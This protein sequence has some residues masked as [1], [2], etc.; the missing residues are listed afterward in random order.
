[1]TNKAQQVLVA[2]DNCIFTVAE[3]RLDVLLIQMKQEPFDGVWALPG[4]L[5]DDGE[6]LDGAAA[7]ILEEQTGLRHVYLEQLYSFDDESRDP[8]GRVVSIAYFSLVQ[9]HGLELRTTDKYRQV[10]FW[11]VEG[12]PG[13]L[14][15]DHETILGYARARLTAKVQYTNVMWSLLPEKFTL[16]QL[17]AAYETVLSRRLDKRNFRKKVSSLGIVEAS[18]EKSTGGRHRPAML[19]RFTS[20]EPEIAEVFR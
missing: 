4:G 19:Y 1:M 16:G 14:A 20:H 2:V 8:S 13:K 11:S 3:G 10:R 17:Q 18:G 9:R 5:I 6:R 15:Y 12:L 7:R